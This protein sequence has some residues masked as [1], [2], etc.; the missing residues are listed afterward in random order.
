MEFKEIYGKTNQSKP[1]SPL[2]APQASAFHVLSLGVCSQICKGAVLRVS[3]VLR[4]HLSTARWVRGQPVSS[5]ALPP[6]PLSAPN[7]PSC[8]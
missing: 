1:H 3:P 7:S 5:L 4:I 8:P 2:P 6:A